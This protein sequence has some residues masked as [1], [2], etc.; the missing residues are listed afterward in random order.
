M[1]VDGQNLDANDPAR[2]LATGDP[3]ARTDM[4]AHTLVVVGASFPGGVPGFVILEDKAD[5]AAGNWASGEVLQDH[6]CAIAGQG[7][8][9]RAG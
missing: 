1:R 8:P 3:A 5:R 6:S 7:D 9:R 4:G 2:L